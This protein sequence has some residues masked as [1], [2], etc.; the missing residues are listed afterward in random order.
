MIPNNDKTVAHVGTATE[1]IRLGLDLSAAAHLIG[2]LTDLYSDRVLAVV[3][4]YSTNARDSHI[5]AGNADLPILVSLPTAD[6][7][8]FSV[9]DFGLG[10]NVDD[11]TKVYSLYGNSTKRE[12]D[13]VNGVLGLGCKSALTYAISFTVT[14]VKDGVKT[15]ALVTKD[16][17][18]VGTIKILDTRGTD[19][20]NGVKIAVP[21]EPSHVRK[22]R[23]AAL[24]F[25]KFWDKGT[26]EVDT[27]NSSTFTAP[28][29]IRDQENL[30]WLDEDT[31]VWP[32]GGESYIVQNGVAYPIKD[33]FRPQGVNVI[34]WVTSGLVNFTPSREALHYTPRTEETLVELRDYV[35]ERLPVVL[36]EAVQHLLPFERISIL[37]KWKQHLPKLV[38]RLHREYG[39][40]P[41]LNGRTAW[42]YDTYS[43]R[44]SRRRGYSSLGT[45]SKIQGQLAWFDLVG[46]NTS[47]V[48]DYPFQSVSPAV[49]A[50]LSAL[51]EGKVVII[52]KGVDTTPLTGRDRVSTW[53]DVVALTA[54]E[55]E[56]KEATKR[57]QTKTLYRFRTA[58]GEYYEEASAQSAAKVVLYATYDAG[59]NV[60]LY[61]GAH[62]AVIQDRQVERFL[63]IH[64][65]AVEFSVY[66]EQAREKAYK[67]LR[68][69]DFAY[70]SYSG[71]NLAWL[72][73]HPSLVATIEDPELVEVLRILKTA[74]STRLERFYALGCTFPNDIVFPN[75]DETLIERY[76]FVTSVSR[77]TASQQADDVVLFI[78]AKYTSL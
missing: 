29:S 73:E 77:Y 65:Q 66:R 64:P 21:V 11:L 10:L 23:D 8:F 41:A 25:Y 31:C 30:T 4:E 49:K 36:Y 13:L 45:A 67:A 12:S 34:A 54:D 14:A 38:Q 78:N 24:N 71:F 19:E 47:V 75:L 52:P 53:D 72:N 59:V 74:P 16:H 37:L 33:A 50:R 3:R 15:L 57:V 1:E 2:V 26:V 58:E 42:R 62:L 7:L 55:V 40:G 22:F 27:E 20:L 46:N 32:G 51:F 35:N 39:P 6:N 60:R 61:P 70:H 68:S 76:R 44:Y 63:R 5:D 28:H 17:D 69:D 18:G 43:S 56:V 48:T 9:Q